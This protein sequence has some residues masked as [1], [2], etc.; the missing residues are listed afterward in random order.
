LQALDLNRRK[1][2]LTAAGG[3]SAAIGMGPLATVEA[4]TTGQTATY[5]VFQTTVTY[6]TV[7]QLLSA[8]A[9]VQT[10]EIYL[11]MSTTGGEV[12]GGIE[13]YNFLRSLP[14]KL[15]IH[16]I[17][18]VD[19]IGNAIFLAGKSRIASAHATFMFHGVG[20]QPGTGPLSTKTLMEFLEGNRADEK[21]IGEIIAERTK[22]RADE[23]AKFF[24]E[25]KTLDAAGALSTGII[26]KVAELQMPPGARIVVVGQ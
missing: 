3:L 13:A 7:A 11:I 16:N 25:S 18:N 5:I 4:Q 15:T 14:K 22:L 17:G 24:Q 20:R 6:Q 10:D 9:Q 26:D 21:R 12:K 19:S 8:I 1:V 23:V 2:L